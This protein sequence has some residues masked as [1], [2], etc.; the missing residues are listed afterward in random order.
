MK[1]KHFFTTLCFSLF[2]CCQNN[3]NANT[4][5]SEVGCIESILAKDSELGKTRNHQCET[6]TL[7]KTIENYTKAIQNLKFED[8][9]EEFNLAFKTHISAWNQM[10]EF[11]K[12]YSDLRG[13]M[14]DLFDSIEKTKDSL[15]FKPLLK[16]IWDTWA[17]VEAAKSKHEK[18]QS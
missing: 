11:T 6:I 7:H 10:G 15:V 3:K 9:P 2:F 17:D 14:H 16:T 8:C 4:T 13:E 18:S 5:V 12:T 1:A